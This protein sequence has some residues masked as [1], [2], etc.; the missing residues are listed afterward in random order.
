[1][2]SLVVLHTIFMREHNRVAKELEFLNPHW[3]DDQLFYETR[4]IVVA[5]LQSIT[6]KE[7]L[8]AVLGDLTMEEFDIALSRNGYS[9]DYDQRVNPSITNEFASAAFRFGH[10]MVDGLLK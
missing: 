1:M 8:P 6:Y 2:I 9:Y 10:S 7:F 4:R 5:E 3:N